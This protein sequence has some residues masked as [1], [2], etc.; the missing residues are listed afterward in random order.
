MTV[1]AYSKKEGVI[2]YDSRATT[3]YFIVSDKEEKMFEVNGVKI[4]AAG[5]ICDIERLEREW[6][7]IK[8]SYEISAFIVENGKVDILG[9]DGEDVFRWSV[10]DDRCIGSGRDHAITALDMGATAVE[11]VEWAIKR[12]VGCGGEVK[13]FKVSEK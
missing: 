11:A 8:G 2:A 7:V 1:I 3:D 13:S 6:P 12:D 5:N 10:R 4:I 9:L